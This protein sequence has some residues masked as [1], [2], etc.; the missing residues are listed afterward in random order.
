MCWWMGDQVPKNEFTLH[1][2]F[3]RKAPGDVS[4]YQVFELS[5]SLSHIDHPGP[6]CRYLTGYSRGNIWSNVL[7]CP[8]AAE[9]SFH[10][11]KGHP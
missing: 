8:L 4:R 10:P 9:K 7:N 2:K 5:D 6:V 1:I 11:C 3:Y